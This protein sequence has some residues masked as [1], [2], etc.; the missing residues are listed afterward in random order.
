MGSEVDIRL[1]GFFCL[2]DPVQQLEAECGG[3]KMERKASAYSFK[4]CAPS[5]INLCHL[6][7]L[8]RLSNS[9]HTCLQRISISEGWNH[10]CYAGIARL[11]TDIYT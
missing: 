4:E 11:V 10:H 2:A 9:R 1:W 8:T 3:I 7:A 6:G 5:G